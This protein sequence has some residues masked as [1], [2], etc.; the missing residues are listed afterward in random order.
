MSETVQP[1]DLVLDCPICLSLLFRPISLYCGHSFCEQCIAMYSYNRREGFCP[2]CRS[3]ISLKINKY[4]RNILLEECIKRLKPKEYQEKSVAWKQFNYTMPDNCLKNSLFMRIWAYI[5]QKVGRIIKEVHKWA[6]ILTL[7]IAVA[8]F[9]K[10]R[11][12]NRETEL[13]F[14][15]EDFINVFEKIKNRFGQ[16][17]GNDDE[18]HVQKMVVSKFIKYL[19]TNYAKLALL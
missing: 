13:K 15:K 19:F 16:M 11:K 18:A 7:I 6:P 12:A 4:H 3:R 1:N 8:L 5:C 17:D 9:L 14:S 10:F 2:V